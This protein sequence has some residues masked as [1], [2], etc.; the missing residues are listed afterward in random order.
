MSSR[1]RKNY[2]EMSEDEEA[3]IVKRIKSGESIN[4]IFQEGK[5]LKLAIEL[6]VENSGI[7]YESQAKKGTKKT[8]PILIEDIPRLVAGEMSE[9]HKRINNLWKPTGAR[10]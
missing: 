5:F 8:K 2:L 3:Q 7:S 9:Q 1:V 10:T 4:A 6:A